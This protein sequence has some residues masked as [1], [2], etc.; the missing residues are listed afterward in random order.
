MDKLIRQLAQDHRLPV[1]GY[2][3]ILTQATPADAAL[4]ASLARAE[5]EKHYGSGIFVRG[6]V[7]ISNFCKNDCYYCGIRRS[8]RGCTRYRLTPDEIEACCDE[9][10]RL[11]FHTFVL[12]GGEDAYFSDELLVSLITK[13][14]EKYPDCAITLSLGER[15][16]ESYRALRKAGAD[17]YLLR[18]ETIDPH[19]YRILH[20]EV[21][22]WQSRMDCLHTLQSEGFQVGSGFMVGSPGQT[23]E[24]LAQEL[25]F[26]EQFKPNMCG[27]GPFMPQHDTPFRDQPAGSAE[28][29]C[30]LLSCIRLIHPKILLPATTALA[31]LIPDGREKGILAGAN[32]VMPNLSPASQRQNYALYDNKLSDGAEAAQSLQLLENK[33]NTIGCHID[34]SRGD[35]LR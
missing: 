9:G 25:E 13:I 23:P 8:N 14:K 31:S 30:L 3:R 2:L 27:I 10:Y 7:E 4:L 20:P 12:Q 26:V 34:Y 5:K 33:L 6:L 1:E 16:R 17:R 28:L 35:A 32:V 19:H 15:S 24:M 22:S 11:G 18:H 29:T 21:L